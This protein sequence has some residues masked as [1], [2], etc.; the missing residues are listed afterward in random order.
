MEVI[1]KAEN[2]NLNCD[3][4]Q[5]NELLYRLWVRDSCRNLYKLTIPRTSQTVQHADALKIGIR[6]EIFSRIPFRRVNDVTAELA[7]FDVLT[8]QPEAQGTLH[9]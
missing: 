3:S 8:T 7:D 5:T 2:R 6:V 4:S 9:N 1:R